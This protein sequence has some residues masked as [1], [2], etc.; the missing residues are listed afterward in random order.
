MLSPVRMDCDP[1][2]LGAFLQAAAKDRGPWNCSTLAADWC[3]A[4]GHPD[5][6]AKWRHIVGEVECE[7]AASDG[8]IELWREG[9]GE[10]LPQVPIDGLEVG[11]IAILSLSARWRPVRSGPASAA[12]SSGRK[13]FISPVKIISMSLQHGDP[14]HG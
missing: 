1:V 8:L 13:G 7:E 6:A 2:S 10:T 4:L 3:V 14:E 9:I 5:F 12:P 11:D